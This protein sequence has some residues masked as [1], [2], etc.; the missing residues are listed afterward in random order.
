MTSSLTRLVF[1]NLS[2]MYVFATDSISGGPLEMLVLG[3]SYL[4]ARSMKGNVFIVTKNMLE[5]GGLTDYIDPSS[6]YDIYGEGYTKNEFRTMV[7]EEANLR[8]EP[9]IDSLVS[10]V[11][12][13]RMQRFA[14]F[15]NTEDPMPFGGIMKSLVNVHSFSTEDMAAT[16]EERS[17]VMPS[18]AGYHVFASQD[19]L[20]VAVH[21]WLEDPKEGRSVGE[22]TYVMAF[23]LDGPL[24]SKMFAGTVPG[25]ALNQFSFDQVSGCCGRCRTWFGLAPRFHAPSSRKHKAL[26]HFASFIFSIFQSRQ[27]DPE[28]EDQIEKDFLRLATCSRQRWVQIPGQGESF[29]ESSDENLCQ[30]NVLEIDETDETLKIVGTEDKLGKEGERIY[31]VRFLEE[32][33]FVVTFREIDPFYTLDLSNP[34]SPQKVGELEIPGYSS[35]LHP[36]G[37][38]FVLGVGQLVKD[39]REVAPQISLFDVSD[40]ANPVRKFNFVEK[41]V[42][43]TSTLRYNHKGFRF[44]Q[45]SG[46]LILPLS[47]GLATDKWDSGDA[48]DG[49]QLYRVH[50]VSGIDRYMTIEHAKGDF[51][52]HGCWSNDGFLRRRSVAVSG[53]LRT[54]SGHS[55]VFSDLANRSATEIDLPINLDDDL[56]DLAGDNCTGTEF[57]YSA[58]PWIHAM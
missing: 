32:R 58:A 5:I 53:V 52:D 15:Q 46:I 49:F 48:F 24:V 56:A 20:V 8:I 12:C 37:K 6:N 39:G 21:G 30:I 7:E 42:N 26:L 31:S 57:Y 25:Y 41:E 13:N 47:N 1:R 9:L 33:A 40:F 28:S 43:A 45:E 51:A 4:S 38:D 55:I 16:L 35:F 36:I 10:E 27:V 34:R 19:Y 11:D 18:N 2:Q 54:F 29:W 44:I 22:E 23:K 14:L 3:G 50:E 17:M